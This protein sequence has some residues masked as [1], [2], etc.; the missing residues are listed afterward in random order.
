MMGIPLEQAIGCPAYLFVGHG[1]H[2]LKL[3]EFT[4]QQTITF[5]LV[6]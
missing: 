4:R 2:Q 1:L 3:K 6:L 5:I